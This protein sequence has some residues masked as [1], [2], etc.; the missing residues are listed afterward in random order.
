MGDLPKI[1][2]DFRDVLI[3]AFVDV[4]LG[5]ENL[6]DELA[7][8]QEKKLTDELRAAKPGDKFKDQKVL[9]VDAAADTITLRVRLSNIAVPAVPRLKLG[10]VQADL[11]VERWVNLTDPSKKR[12]NVVGVSGYALEIDVA[13][14]NA[15]QVRLGYA[16]DDSIANQS[17]MLFAS[18]KWNA[19]SFSLVGL[20]GQSDVGGLL[21][22][23]TAEAPVP[24]PLGP[25]MTGLKGVGLLFGRR[26]APLLG[27]AVPETAMAKL[28]EASAIDYVDWSL[29]PLGLDT[30]AAVPEAI[31][32]YGIKAVLV[33]MLA[34]GGLGKLTE[35]G[36]A[37]ISFGPTIIGGGN[38]KILEMMDAG[39]LTGAVDFK[40]QSILV[41]AVESVDVIPWAHGAIKAEGTVELSASL[42]D[43]SK[44]YIA[45][46][47][48][49]MDGCT[50]KVLGCI[51]LHGGLRISF[52]EGVAIRASGRL[53]AE[54]EV[55]GFGG[56]F[57]MWIDAEGSIGWNPINVHCRLYVGGSIW[58]EALGG[59]LGFGGA[60]IPT[61][62][63]C[64]HRC[65]FPRRQRRH[66]PS[67]NMVSP[68]TC[69][70]TQAG[71][72]PAPTATT[73][74]AHS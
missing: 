13:E 44:F 62:C 65:W 29:K 52:N 21:I 56:G 37:Y 26:F 11:L 55:V 49:A 64:S 36:L 66:V 12:V 67:P 7:K 63:R 61:S 38:L 57:D 42:R 51:E 70:P 41:R 25:T 32:T 53:S 60:R 71:S 45:I 19:P 59:K 46:G 10:T 23:V 14:E 24:I 47:N 27:D 40:S 73:R 22:D 16:E 30:W 3:G 9:H 1:P 35:F 2:S 4:V 39:R 34:G 18:V 58:V 20:L 43:P 15:Y 6:V 8:S 33:D 68:M 17:K 50:M 31:D 69:R 5:A 28:A 74:P 48:R 54:G 72:T